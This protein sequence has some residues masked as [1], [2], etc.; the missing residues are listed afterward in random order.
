MTL[1][2]TEVYDALRSANVPEDAAKKAA[3][4]VATYEPQLADTRS[5]LRLLKWM[6]GTNVVLTL[7]MLGA[8][9]GIY[10]MLFDIAARLPR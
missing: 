3:A 8:I 6:V 5:D 4:A 1:M 2:I 7:A 9:A 10:T